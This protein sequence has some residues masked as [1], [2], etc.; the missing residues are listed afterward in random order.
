MATATGTY[1]TSTTL[2]RR[3]GITDST[4]DT[5]IGEIV[6]EV[7]QFIETRTGRILSPVTHTAVLFD[8]YD[9]IEGGRC[10]HIPQGIRSISLLEVTATTGGT[11]STV[12]STDYFIRPTAHER[13]PGW[14]GTEVWMTDIPSAANSLPVFLPGYANIRLTGTGGWAAVPD[15]I[16]AIAMRCGVSAW[17]GRS[18][19]G[20]DDFSAGTDGERTFSAALSGK[21]WK[22]LERYRVKTV[23]II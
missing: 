15:D 13:D 18:S 12:P 7:N 1:I 14:P 4:D 10:L 21:D 8:G 11:F 3:L 9:A 19:S 5:L 6:N 22:T 17:R 16:A 20:T 23:H 2:K